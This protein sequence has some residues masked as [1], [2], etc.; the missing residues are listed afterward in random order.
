M[1]GLLI[2]HTTESIVPLILNLGIVPKS[3]GPSKDSGVI[4]YSTGLGTAFTLEEAYEKIRTMN[5][6]IIILINK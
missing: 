5:K 3:R 4:V 6:I 1:K 2:Q